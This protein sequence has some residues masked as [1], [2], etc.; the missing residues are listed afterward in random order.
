MQVPL[1]R[2]DDPSGSMAWH[3]VWSPALLAPD[4]TSSE[5]LQVRTTQGKRADIVGAG[6]T[7]LMTSR[8]VF[9]MGIDKSR[10]SAAQAAA[11]APALAAIL[12][13]DG[14]SYAK[15]V[16]SA[17]AKQFVVGLT[18]R[19]SDPLAQKIA[20][21]QAV[22]GGAAVPGNEVLGPTST[23]AKAILG[24]VG[25]VTAEMVQKSGGTLKAGDV[26]GLSGLEARY[27]AQLRGSSG[28]T[29][30][31]A[32]TDGPGRRCPRSSTRGPPPTGHRC[33]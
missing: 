25:D 22:P 2:H 33:R 12:G 28:L 27:D 23:F 1:V 21:V 4:L 24:T 5:S 13:I 20:Q 9:Q 3:A 11:S 18:V 29:V 6:N 16:A 15:K 7:P 10:V 30:T 31:A 8:P 19:S 17:G 26:A 14:A 32:G